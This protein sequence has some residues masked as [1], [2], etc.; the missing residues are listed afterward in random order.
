MDQRGFGFGGAL[1]LV[2]IV[3]LLWNFDV[4]PDRFWPVAWSLWP[5]ALVAVG[6]GLALSRVR[7]WLGSTAFLVVLIAGFGT[8]W[9][10]AAAGKGPVLHHR[11]I[12]VERGQ[13]TAVRLEVNVGAGSLS[14]GAQA[15]SGLLIAGNLESR[16]VDIDYAIS[17]SHQP[18]GRSVIELGSGPGREFSIWPGQGSSEDWHLHLTPDIPTEVRVE[19]GAADIDL[20]LRG[21]R[22]QLLEI[23]GGAA[24][25][26]VVMPAAA[27]RTEASIEVGAASLRIT[28]PEGV[29]ARIEVDAGLS[30][31][32][33]DED[34]FPQASDD[35]YISPDF[36]RAANR[37]D[38]TI[39]AGASHVE[40][41]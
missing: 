28:V 40:I 35:V 12:A 29:T 27:G 13:A 19:A 31:I 9:G 17:E 8:A 33:I 18:G 1:I 16:A 24:D 37:V 6:A 2:G 5:V 41:R 20:N 15:P 25:I 4:L 36:D 39:D 26:D 10:L 21:L 23:E 7:A 32:Q 38:I 14:L 34:R 22:L 3:A 30:S 11:T